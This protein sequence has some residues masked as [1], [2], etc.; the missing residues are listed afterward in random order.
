MEP[1]EILRSALELIRDE[2]HWCQGTFARDAHGMATQAMGPDAVAWCAYGALLKT[3]MLCGDCAKA[4]DNSAGQLFG[5]ASAPFINDSFTHA[6]VLVM[7]K[8]AIADLEAGQ[9]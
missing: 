5:H 7:F 6:D 3:Q 8:Q 4:L 2:D 9:L 1:V